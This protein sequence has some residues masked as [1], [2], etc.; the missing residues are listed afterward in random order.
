MAYKDTTELV[1]GVSSVFHEGRVA[2]ITGAGSGIGQAA[3]VE[4]AK[5]VCSQTPSSYLQSKQERKATN[6]HTISTAQIATNIDSAI[7]RLKLK[8]AIADVNEAGLQETVRLAEA[9]TDPKPNILVVPTDVTKKEQVEQLR[10]KVYETWG[11]VSA[12]PQ[13]LSGRL[14]CCHP[15][16]NNPSWLF[17]T[18]VTCLFS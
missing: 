3:A 6:W 16:I 11:E 15:S 2:V 10:D 5:Y 13:D 8:I 12:S 4:F 14:L 17:G 1:D 9:A 7:R 18:D